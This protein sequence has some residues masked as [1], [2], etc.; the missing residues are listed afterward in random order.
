MSKQGFAKTSE[1]F[2]LGKL[3]AKMSEATDQLKDTNGAK[4]PLSVLVVEDSEFDARMLVGLLK[5]GGFIPTFKRVETASEMVEAL[6]HEKWEVIL[7]DYNL[8]E[9]SAPKALEVLRNTKLDIPFI[10]VSGGIGEDTAV[11]AMREGANDYLMKGNLARLVPAVERELRD[12]AVRVSRRKAIKELRESEMR[13]R[14]LIENASDIIVVLNSKGVVSF[15]SPACEKVLGKKE[16]DFIGKDWFQFAEESFRLKIKN[17][18]FRSL[19]QKLVSFSFEGRFIDANGDSRVLDATAQNLLNDEAIEGVVLNVR[20][21]TERLKSQAAIRDSAEEFR[22]AR[23]IQQHLFPKQAPIIDGFDIAGAS[24]PAAATGG[25]YF[26]YLKTTDGQLVLAVA[27]VSGHGAGP[28]MLMAETRAYL[29]LLVRNR[30]HLGDIL[31]RANNM[32]GEDV[33]KD[34][35]ITMHL[36]K[37]DSKSKMIAHSSSGHT[38]GYIIGEKGQIKSKMKRTGIALGV[39]PDAP[40]EVEGPLK[41]VKGDIIILLT[42]GLAE[43]PNSEGELFGAQRVIDELHRNRSLSAAEIVNSVFKMVADFSQGAEQEDD[44]TMIVAKVL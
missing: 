30:H 22:V 1:R 20:D 28:A 17:E 14:T 29:R 32:V 42:D 11:A 4:L 12:A 25:D 31:A 15:I 16:D 18:Y 9:F 3:K 23:E 33:G 10:I 21:V 26:D 41:L 7:A 2:N 43:T 40:Y 19:S 13:H 24:S 35:F 6:N 34:R 38:P 36:V 44:Y 39:T 37:L 27:D 8:P 5:S